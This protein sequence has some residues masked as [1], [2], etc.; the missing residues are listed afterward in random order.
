M[1]AVHAAT[2]ATTVARIVIVRADCFVAGDSV[3]W[4]YAS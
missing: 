4:I 2:P 3:K 1:M